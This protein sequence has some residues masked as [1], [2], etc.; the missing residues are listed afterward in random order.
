MTGKTMLT[1]S[2]GLGNPRN[3]EGDI[4]VL[5]DGRWVYAYSRFTGGCKDNGAADI[6]ARF[7]ENNGKSW[8]ADQILVANRGDENIMSVSF[9]ALPSGEILLFY[10]LKN[11]FLDNRTVVERYTDKLQHV[12]GPH[13]IMPK[14]GYFVLNNA[15]V[16]RLSN[17]RIVVPAA[18]HHNSG[19]TWADFNSRGTAVFFYSDDDGH[20]WQQSPTTLEG[21]AE[22]ATGLQEPGVIEL[23]N[24][25]LLM[26]ART[27]LGCQ[28]QAI[29]DDGGMNWNSPAPGPLKSPVSPAT[30]ARIP[31]NQALLA[32]W[33]DHS[34]HHSFP[35]KK[36]T[37][38]T[39]AIS[40][41]EGKTWSPSKIIR[42]QADGWYCYT[43]I[44]FIGDDAV[45]SFCDGDSKVGGLNQS[46]L[47]TLSRQILDNQ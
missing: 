9:L 40:R 2:P 31:W 3:S 10:S 45:L 18:Q 30:I 42:N 27:D 17:G 22:S 11:S 33:N 29:S 12:S 14:N 36:R 21:P 23:L 16:Q 38:L 44:T 28:F 20:S 41:D 43:S 25:Q 26:Y 39:W 24:G 34:G 46:S 7:S 35:A 8:S 1:I 6:T 32:V 13:Y 37:P 4:I 47:L 15:R 5:R 19:K